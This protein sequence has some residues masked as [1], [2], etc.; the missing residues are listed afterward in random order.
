M[1]MKRCPVCG[2]RYSDTYKDCPFCEEEELWE[3]EEPRRPSR[4]SR[5]SSQ[6]SLVTPILIVLIVLMS[7]LLVY[8]LYGDQI[9]G[10]LGGDKD[11]GDSKPGVSQP[12]EP[13]PGGNEPAGSTE[14]SGDG[15]EPADSNEP[16]GNTEPSGGGNE[17]AGST[18]GDSGQTGVMPEGPDSG[19]SGNAGDAGGSTGT[20]GSDG[21][22]YA[23]LSQLPGGLTLSNPDFTRS[24]SE[25]VYR[26]RVSGGSGSYTWVSEN[27]AIATVDKDGN[28]TPVSAGMV[29]ILATDGSKKAIG[30]VRVTGGS[31]PASTGSSGGSSG[32]GGASKLNREDMTLAVGESWK[33]T[34]SG[35]T[36]TLTWHVSDSGIA[37]VGGDG[38]VTG[39]SKGMTTVT[40][41]WD[42]Q[43][44]SCIV[45][46]K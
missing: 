9:A 28:V 20:S 33:L 5:R 25:G 26:L 10:K 39:V 41:S 44:R 8:L 13:K 14:P 16:A 23:S 4:G 31:A 22:S 38:T 12:V 24:V 3:E 37:T 21:S 29:H 17:P 36:S 42:G 6:F 46:V 2:E 11:P 7:A 1:A 32:S 35:V 18:D 30:I 27:P 34:L 40:V 15:S 45:R 43:S 19:A